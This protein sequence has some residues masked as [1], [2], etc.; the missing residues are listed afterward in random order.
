MYG[1]AYRVIGHQWR[2]T[3]RRSQLHVRLRSVR[4]EPVATPGE[5]VVD[6]V[7][8]RL[9]LAALAALPV[10][11]TP[12]PHR[13]APSWPGVCWHASPLRL[14]SDMGHPVRAIEVQPWRQPAGRATARGSSATSGVLHRRFSDA[15]EPP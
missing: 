7:D 13:S 2:S 10:R 1:V 11:P 3:A 9:V 8:D 5:L 15:L 14:V 4:P 12:R 6:G